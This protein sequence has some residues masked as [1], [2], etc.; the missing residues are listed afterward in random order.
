MGLIERRIVEEPWQEVSADLMELPQFKMR[1]KYLIVFEDL[2]TL[3]IEVKPVPRATRAA[4]QKA[5]EDLVI[6]RWRTPRRL[7]VD[8]WS[9]FDNKRTAELVGT[10]SAPT[11]PYHH[12]ANSTERC[13]RTLKPMI[14]MF[15]E[16]DHREG[17]IHIHEF[18]NAVTHASTKVA[19]AYLNF[20]RLPL[21]VSSLRLGI[22]R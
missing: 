4:V 9:E 8:N 21:P 19:P 5:W 7:I 17:H 11:P 20:G 22:R 18:R 13:N 16:K 2:F 12:R 15:V 10:K 14:A 1:N 3:W 6:F